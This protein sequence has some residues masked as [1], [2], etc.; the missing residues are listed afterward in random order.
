MSRGASSAR[1]WWSLH[2]RRAV[3]QPQHRALAAQRLADQEVLRLRVVQA[4][5]V[6]LVELHVRD[7]G[8]RAVRHRH[9]VAGRDVGVRRVE[10][11][12]AGAAGREHRR[13]REDRLRPCPCSTSSTYAPTQTSGPPNF[14][15]VIRSIA[16]CSSSTRMFGFA[17]D[18][19]R[20]ARARPRAPVMS[21]ACTTRRAL[22]PPSSAGRGRRRRRRALDRRRERARRARSSS[23]DARSGPRATHELDDA[24]R[25]RGRR[26]RRACRSTCASNES[27]VVEHRRDAALRVVRVRLVARALGDDDDLAVLG[28]LEGEGEAGDAAADH[29]EVARQGHGSF[30][31][32]ASVSLIVAYS[33]SAQHR[34]P[35]A[36]SSFAERIELGPHDARARQASRTSP[37]ARCSR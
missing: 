10:V 17:R 15:S 1:A 7:L 29:E 35:T 9:A 18:A 28:R 6:E 22:C 32:A 37:A 24:R 4:G 31:H 5:R 16:M 26:R 14:A 13:A 27:S 3:E 20:A 23:R 8:A 2:E 11:D 33:A 34:V 12:L 36:R 19:P 30:Y 25:G 21:P